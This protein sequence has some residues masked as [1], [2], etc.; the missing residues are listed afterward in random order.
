MKIHTITLTKDPKRRHI[1]VA[2]YEGRD[3]TPGLGKSITAGL[4]CK[5]HNLPGGIVVTGLADQPLGVLESVEKI[6]GYLKECHPTATLIG[7]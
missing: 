3:V 1:V 7:A 2:R 6:P 5:F 4:L